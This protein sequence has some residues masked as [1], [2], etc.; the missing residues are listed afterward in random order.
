[1]KASILNRVSELEERENDLEFVQRVKEVEEW[2][3]E[4]KR[5]Y[6]SPEQV[7]LRRKRYEEIVA[8]G[9]ARRERMY[10]HD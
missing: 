10:S 1:M 7:K 5:I 8:E 2:Y 4:K 3:A 6:N 9:K